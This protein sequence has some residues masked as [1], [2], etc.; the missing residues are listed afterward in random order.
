MLFRSG[1][2]IRRR[3]CEAGCLIDTWRGDRSWSYQRGCLAKGFGHAVGELAL[4]FAGFEEAEIAGG[5]E[6]DVV[7]KGDA[8][9]FAGLF[10]LPGDI[11]VRG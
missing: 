2:K 3:G 8:E 4:E 11:D 10:D 1:F 6:N 9:D 7:K 5:V